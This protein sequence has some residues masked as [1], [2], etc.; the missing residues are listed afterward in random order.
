MTSPI[1]QTW[2]KRRELLI[3]LTKRD[4]LQKYR[5]S[6]LGVMWSVLNPLFLLG[7]YT[8][9][10]GVFLHMKW[11]AEHT[12]LADF[13]I[14]LFCGLVPFTYFNEA[15]SRSA[16]AIISAPNFVKRIAFPT[17]MLPIVVNTSALVH[18]FVNTLI[19]I[20]AVG[21]A[22]GTL[23]VTV[24]L[25]PLIWIPVILGCIALSL[26]VAA[27]GGFIRDLTHIV[28]VIFSVLFFLS[29]IFYPATRVP[30][31]A[32]FILF[33][34][35]IAYAATNMRKLIVLGETPNWLSWAGL[36]LISLLALWLSVRYFFALQRR[37][38]DVL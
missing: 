38:A 16:T 8:T 32:Q 23:H 6:V 36:T 12:G 29:P 19:L 28:G 37:F 9:A 26:V 3:A 20:A 30:E 7:I 31:K 10:F 18:V 34:N 14:M 22:H 4:V 21:I 1:I 15:I 24:L 17:E 25:V 11:D 5:G 33:V 27:V 13:A 35:P 2:T